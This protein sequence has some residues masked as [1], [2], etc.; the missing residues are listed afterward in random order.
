ML[1]SVWLATYSAFSL[2]ENRRQE[3]SSDRYND[4]KTWPLDGRGGSLAGS[5]STAAILRIHTAIMNSHLKERQVPYCFTVRMLV[6]VKR[7]VHL[8]PATQRCRLHYMATM[9]VL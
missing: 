5:R 9:Q 3:Q 2:A 1:Q 4:P 7:R 8:S 6:Y